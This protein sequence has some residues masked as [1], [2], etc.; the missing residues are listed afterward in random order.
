VFFLADTDAEQAAEIMQRVIGSF[1]ERFA[2]TR[3]PVVSLSYF[4]VVPGAGDVT[5]KQVL[6]A[7]F[8][9]NG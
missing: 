5:V 2:T 7:L 3:S 4:E 9:R 8:A 1:Q 6:P